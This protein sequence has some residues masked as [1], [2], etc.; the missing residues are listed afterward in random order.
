MLVVVLCWVQLDYQNH[1]QAMLLR[2][3]RHRCLPATVQRPV[4]CWSHGEPPE[5]IPPC[6]AHC[7]CD[8]N[9]ILQITSLDK[10]V[11]GL[12]SKVKLRD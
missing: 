12:I 4:S 7:I 8:Q 10:R 6:A 3:V 11:S 2:A 5:F 9:Q 1:P